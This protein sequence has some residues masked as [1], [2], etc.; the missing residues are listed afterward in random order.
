MGST[1]RPA[2]KTA[3]LAVGITIGIGLLFS[4]FFGVLVGAL[5][6]LGIGT[7]FFINF[8]KGG[9]TAERISFTIALIFG[10]LLLLYFLG[11]YGL[12][13]YIVALLAFYFI[14]RKPRKDGADVPLP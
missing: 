4:Y 14:R 7:V 2:L 9:S 12:V 8:L 5:V 3:L 6:F 11:V 1:S 13:V 10:M